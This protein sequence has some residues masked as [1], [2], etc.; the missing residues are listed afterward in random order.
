MAEAP[1]AGGITDPAVIASSSY[2]REV[3]SMDLEP[4]V[5]ADAS[6]AAHRASSSQA[7]TNCGEA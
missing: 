4:I 1:R 6:S 3:A 7:G 2:M 5:F